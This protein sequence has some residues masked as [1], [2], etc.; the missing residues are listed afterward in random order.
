M[1][2]ANEKI[3]LGIRRYRRTVRRIA[4]RKN[5][6][7]GEAKGATGRRIPAGTTGDVNQ[8][9]IRAAVPQEGESRPVRRSTQL[10]RRTEGETGTE[11]EERKREIRG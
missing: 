7:G 11:E 6:S 9:V 3:K 4:S 2:P 1:G 10:E 8:W 5:R